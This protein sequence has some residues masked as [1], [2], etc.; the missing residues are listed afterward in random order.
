MDIMGV[1]ESPR[2]TSE[3]DKSEVN[4]DS[5]SDG[6]DYGNDG[7]GDHVVMEEENIENIHIAA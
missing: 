7:S 4:A 1:R 2:V 6:D 5:D 3:E